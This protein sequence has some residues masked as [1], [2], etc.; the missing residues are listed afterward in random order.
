MI[1]CNPETCPAGGSIREFQAYLA[2]DAKAWA[3]VVKDYDIKA[4]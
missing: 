3:K 1:I 2:E 4:E